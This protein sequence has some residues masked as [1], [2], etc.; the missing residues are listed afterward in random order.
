[1]TISKRNQ[2][3]NIT[4]PINTELTR[5]RLRRLSL[6]GLLANYDDI[7]DAEWLL[8]VIEYEEA[9]RAIR[10]L[11]RRLSNARLGRFKPM[12]DF[13]WT[14]P[15]QIDRELVEE[16]FTL[17]FINEGVNAIFLGPNG[18]GKSTVAQNLAHK[19]IIHG[20][21]VRFTTASDMLNDLAAQDN[22]QSLSRRLKRYTKPNL[23]VI[24][25]VGYLSYDVRYA[26]L[27][28]EVVTR[29]YNEELAI[30]LTTN[31][32]FAQWPETFPNASCVVTLVDR[33][34]HRSE[35][36]TIEGGSYRLHE[37]KERAARRAEKRKKTGVK[38]SSPKTKRAGAS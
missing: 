31:T 17:N 36:V 7:A 38:R 20:H 4:K 29:R 24:D 21:T 23:L 14:W 1:M 15:K 19:A 2:M 10:S 8:R 9:E 6:W 13:Q 30:V 33:L 18:V 25:E 11:Q 34:I 28:F 27:L 12:A 22:E 26:D 35:I 5:E 37:A 32:P 16:L 3:P